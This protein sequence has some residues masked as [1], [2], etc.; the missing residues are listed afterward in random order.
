MDTDGVFVTLDCGRTG[1]PDARF[2][3]Y[4]DVY[5]VEYAIP[6]NANYING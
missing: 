6:F 3:H 4:N 2:L 5:H 1:P